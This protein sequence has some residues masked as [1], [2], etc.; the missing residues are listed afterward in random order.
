LQ[1][2]T[3][4]KKAIYL[5]NDDY[6]VSVGLR[7]TNRKIGKSVTLYQQELFKKIPRLATF[8]TQSVN[9]GLRVV[10]TY[11]RNNNTGVLISPQLDQEGNGSP[12]TCNPEETGL[13]GL[14]VS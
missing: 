10:E 12:V 11:R 7:R 3:I 8:F 13:L 14:P 1:K 9:E 5:L 6:F 2:H 4:S